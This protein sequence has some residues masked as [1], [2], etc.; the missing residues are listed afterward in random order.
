M[1]L[2]GRA[3]EEYD[4]DLTRFNTDEGTTVGVH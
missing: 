1:M 3:H 2:Q 4:L